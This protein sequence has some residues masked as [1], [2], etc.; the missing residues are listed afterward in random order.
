MTESLTRKGVQLEL[1]VWEEAQRRVTA[2][3]E[4]LKAQKPKGD[5]RKVTISE[6]IADA[7]VKTGWNP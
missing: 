4:K 2:K 3:E 5:Y 6:V 7:F 1:A